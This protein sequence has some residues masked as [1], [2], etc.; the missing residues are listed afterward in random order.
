[1]ARLKARTRRFHNKFPHRSTFKSAETW[2]TSF[3]SLQ[4]IELGL[5]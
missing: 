4:N 2:V 5:S 1:M 3:T